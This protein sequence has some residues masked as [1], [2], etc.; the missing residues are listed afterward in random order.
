MDKLPVRVS[1]K[2]H[3]HNLVEITNGSPIADKTGNISNMSD[4][5][6]GN[7]SYKQCKDTFLDAAEI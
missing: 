1:Q 6:L 4:I 3:L 2:R 7:I 5:D